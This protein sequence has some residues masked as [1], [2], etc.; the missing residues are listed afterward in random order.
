M[1][2]KKRLFRLFKKDQ[3]IEFRVHFQTTKLSFFTSNKDKIPLLSS[4]S[5][6][7]EF[8]CPGCMKSYIGKTE[9]TL[10]NRTYEHGWKDKKSAINKHL[11]SCSA[12]RD[13]VG[14]FAI[15]GEDV[16]LRSFQINSVREKSGQLVKTCVPGIYR[17]KRTRSRTEQRAKILQRFSPV[18]KNLTQN[19]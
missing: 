3:K 6:I 8:S 10:F 13:I 19:I 5:V 1:R 18:L 4:S 9:S 7:Y 17:N 15:D 16:D 12:W 11:E 14:L 2:C